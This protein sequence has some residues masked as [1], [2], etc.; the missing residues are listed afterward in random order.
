M[1]SCPSIILKFEMGKLY[2]R[3]VVA[4]TCELQCIV[5]LQPEKK[6]IWFLIR[7]HNIDVGGG[8]FVILLK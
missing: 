3:T 6:I 8:Q 7:S 4:H 5:F 1:S 2:T